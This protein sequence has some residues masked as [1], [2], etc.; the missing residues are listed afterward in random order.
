LGNK[1]ITCKCGH[2]RKDHEVPGELKRFEDAILG[3]RYIQDACY[4]G[5]VRR[6]WHANWECHC[7]HYT[8]DNLTH[9]EILAKERKLI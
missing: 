2:S 3:P 6:D 9:I 7:N 4:V 1:N 5:P 8:P